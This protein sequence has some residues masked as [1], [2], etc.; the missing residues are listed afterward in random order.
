MR[1]SFVKKMLILLFIQAIKDKTTILDYVGAASS[2]E[3]SFNAFLPIY[4]TGTICRTKNQ[5]NLLETFYGVMLRS[6]ELLFTALIIVHLL[7]R[8]IEFYT[9]PVKAQIL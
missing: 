1:L 9:T 8:L 6:S 2:T 3:A 7:E 5:E 4:K